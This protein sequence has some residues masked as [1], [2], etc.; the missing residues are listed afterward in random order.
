[1]LFEIGKSLAGMSPELY[2][3]CALRYLFILAYGCYLWKLRDGDGRGE[4]R[5]WYYAAGAL[6]VAYIVVF[7]YTGRVPLFT[8]QWTKTSV[9]AVLFLVPVMPHLMGKESLRCALLELL[10]KASYH[11]FLVQMLYYWAAARTVYRFVPFAPLRVA[12]NLALCCACGVLFYKIESPI[13][14]WIIRSIRNA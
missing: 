6:G 7:Q 5:L 4:N 13:S 9:F 11:I 1:M 14:Q 10:G 12:V 3:I 2:R 8:D